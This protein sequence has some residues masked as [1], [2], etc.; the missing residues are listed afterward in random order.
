MGFTARTRVR[1]LTPHPERA[2]SLR[3]AAI[4]IAAATGFFGLRRFLFAAL[5]LGGGGLL[6]LPA[7]ASAF[8]M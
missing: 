4:G 1:G 6:G 8:A 3:A 2:A 7:A 5:G